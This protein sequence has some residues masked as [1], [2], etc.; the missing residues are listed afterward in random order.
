MNQN[1]TSARGPVSLSPDLSDRAPVAGDHVHSERRVQWDERLQQPGGG[2]GGAAQEPALHQTGQEGQEAGE[3]QQGE[4][5]DA[6]T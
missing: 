1:K 2:E 4:T 6:R 3:Q 5:E